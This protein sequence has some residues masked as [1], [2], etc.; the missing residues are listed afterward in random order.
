MPQCFSLFCEF[1]QGAWDWQEPIPRHHAL[2]VSVC[3][4]SD[5]I[6]AQRGAPPI[7][8]LSNAW[9]SGE[10]QWA[11]VG[12]GTQQASVVD[13]LA[14]LSSVSD[15]GGLQLVVVTKYQRRL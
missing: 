11:F 15:G 6:W 1:V 7:E 14:R 9:E 10:H 5:H 2:R 8:H 4:F 12:E 13:T 3:V